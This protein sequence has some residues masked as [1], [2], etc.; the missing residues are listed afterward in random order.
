MKLNTRF[1]RKVSIVVVL[2]LV[3]LA[4]VA[5]LASAQKP[6]IGVSI[7]SLSEERWEREKMMMEDVA[8]ELGADIIFTD[9]NHDEAL[10]NSQSRT[11]LLGALMCW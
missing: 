7:R 1:A 4:G 2:S 6:L 5:A 10:Q 3:V 9:A 8:H 11:S